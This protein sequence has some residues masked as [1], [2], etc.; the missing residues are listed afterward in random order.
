MA[1]SM[2]MTSFLG[3]YA[4]STSEM[5]VNFYRTTRRNIPEHI[6]SVLG[7]MFISKYQKI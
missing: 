6:I 3:I 2:K 1:A 7:K 4:I 5:Y